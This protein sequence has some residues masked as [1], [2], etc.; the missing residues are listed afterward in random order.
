VTDTKTDAVFADS[1]RPFYSS[2]EVVGFII[3]SYDNRNSYSIPVTL[4]DPWSRFQGHYIIQ[5][6]VQ[7]REL[8][9]QW[10]INSK[11]YM[12]YQ[13]VPF[14]ITSNG[15]QVHAIVQVAGLV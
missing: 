7:D 12:I 3:I 9:L 11:S 4:N 14:S 13:M 2:L 10:Q 1:S 8:Y 15:F 5:R 6:P